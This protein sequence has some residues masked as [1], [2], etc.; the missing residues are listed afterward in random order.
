MSELNSRE[1][2]SQNKANDLG[3]IPPLEGENTEISM[4]PITTTLLLF[5][6]LSG[7]SG[8]VGAANG[9]YPH[10]SGCSQF[11]VCRAGVAVEKTC[12]SGLMWNKRHNA[13]D[14]AANVPCD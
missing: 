4:V 2:V 11:V 12:P 7:P 10:V 6:W 8:C 5:F 13:C 3:T 1:L 14:V 9:S